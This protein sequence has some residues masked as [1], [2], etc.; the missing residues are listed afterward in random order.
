MFIPYVI[1]VIWSKNVDY[2][3]LIQTSFRFFYADRHLKYK[4]IDNLLIFDAEMG[5][6]KFFRIF[7]CW[8]F[9]LMNFVDIDTKNIG[10]ID[11]LNAVTVTLYLFS[12]SF[13]IMLFAN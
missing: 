13:G 12:S 9:R 1:K 3:Y 11:F 2:R 5:R 8:L 7:H 6:P 4:E 10:V